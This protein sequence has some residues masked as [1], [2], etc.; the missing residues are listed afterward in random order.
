MFHIPIH[1]IIINWQHDTTLHPNTRLTWSQFI[2]YAPF[3][4]LK[5]S[6]SDFLTLFCARTKSWF[7]TVA[8][9][10]ILLGALV[11]ALGLS[12]IFAL[13]WPFKEDGESESCLLCLSCS[14]LFL[15]LYSDNIP[16]RGRSGF[17]WI[18]MGILHFV[19]LCARA[20]QAWLLRIIE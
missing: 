20:S 15:T 18:Y 2:F 17:C 1:Y 13:T 3:R 11:V 12:T 7:F 14:L 6:I 4:Y 8:P 16:R 10:L 5:I 19:V 9:A